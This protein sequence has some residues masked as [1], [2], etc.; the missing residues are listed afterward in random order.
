MNDGCLKPSAC[1]RDRMCDSDALQAS[2][3]APWL[4]LAAAR[5]SA[6]WQPPTLVKG[7]SA[8]FGP[9]PG[10]SR[11]QC[12]TV[13]RRQPRCMGC[14][15]QRQPTAR[16]L[17]SMPFLLSKWLAAGAAVSG[18]PNHHLPPPRQGSTTPNCE[19]IALALSLKPKGRDSES[20]SPRNPRVGQRCSAS[21]Q[22]P[23][24]INRAARHPGPGPKAAAIAQVRRGR[25]TPQ[26]G[27]ESRWSRRRQEM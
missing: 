15:M 2:T 1:E 10:P 11:S 23:G 7:A 25:P 8:G 27:R 26:T 17:P 4:V 22:M 24:K 19:F 13:R 14:C 9:G 16:A 18:C 12:P 20:G 6:Q 3:F 21:M 5:S